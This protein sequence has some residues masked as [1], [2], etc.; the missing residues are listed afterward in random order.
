MFFSFSK[1]QVEFL[2]SSVL[3][4]ELTTELEQQSIQ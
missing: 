3:D 4:I 1:Q 2:A